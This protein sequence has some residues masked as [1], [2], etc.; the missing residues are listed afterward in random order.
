MSKWLSVVLL[1][2][3]ILTVAMGLKGVVTAKGRAPVTVAL[4][5]GVVPPPPPSLWS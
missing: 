5:G 1:V 2:L 3:L 4:G